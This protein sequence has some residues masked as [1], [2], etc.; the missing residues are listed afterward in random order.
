MRELEY[1]G[2]IKLPLEQPGR[3]WQ[4]FVIRVSERKAQLVEHLEA[5]GVG[6]LGHN[7]IPNHFY[8]KLN[9]KFNLPKT[10]QYIREQ[11]RIPCNENLTNEEVEYV[12]KNI[13]NFF[14]R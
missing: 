1:Q 13:Q 11:I 8:P 7:L 10:E 2:Y 14:P 12:I 9:L 5:N 6:I 4:D 3:V